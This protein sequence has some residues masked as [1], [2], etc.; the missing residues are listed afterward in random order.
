MD[1]PA[2]SSKQPRKI[3]M[4]VAL[5]A[6]VVVLILVIAVAFPRVRDSEKML[7]GFW[8][9]DPTFLEKSGLSEMFLYVSPP[10]PGERERQGYL[11]MKGGDG[12]IVSNQGLSLDLRGRP[13]SRWASALK[14][15]FSASALESY[16]VPKVR[17]AYD[18]IPVMPEEMAL[19]LNAADGTLALHSDGKIHAFLVKDNETS[20][21]ANEAYLDTD[22]S[23]SPN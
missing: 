21:T 15:N 12:S 17:V 22:D 14:S 19:S 8:S 13:A 9:G 18:D 6:L 10:S 5:A 16:R 11:V 1:A 23:L 4:W 3:L 7:S 20:I 2:T